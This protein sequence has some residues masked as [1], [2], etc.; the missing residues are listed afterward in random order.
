MQATQSLSADQLLDFL[1][2][3]APV[4]PVFI[5]GAPGIGKSSL[6]ELFAYDV[7]LD[8]VSLLGSQLAP[9]D[10]IGVPQIVDGKSRFCPPRLIARE[11]PF[12]LF[13]DELNACSQ[14]VQK[15]FYS[16]INDRRIGEFELPEGSIVI[17]A[18]NRAQDAAIVKPMSSALVNRMVHIS[19]HADSRSWLKWANGASLH[20]LV[21]EYI[22]LRPDH[23][24][25][26]PP[27]HE[28]PFSTPRSWHMLSDSLYA[29]GDKELNDIIVKQLASGLLTPTH[30]QQF[31]GFYK[32]HQ[33]LYEMNSLFKGEGRWPEKPEERDILYF[34]VQSFQAQLLKTLPEKRK[35]L[36]AEV[37]QMVTQ[38]KDLLIQLSRISL[39]MAQL[40]LAEDERGRLLPDWFMIEV[41]RDLPRLLKR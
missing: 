15:A 26:K 10:I 29:Y 8:C 41:A 35:N 27:K 33:H 11:E 7:G 5:W 31:V 23:L 38:S 6:V 12:C 9:E 3:I 40:V 14:E 4:R 39:E 30:A 21:L 22:G 1:L 36:S 34:M 2:N 18:G 20:S 19:L 32:Q 16:L 37:Q 24:W 13:L 25:S 28:E 17:G